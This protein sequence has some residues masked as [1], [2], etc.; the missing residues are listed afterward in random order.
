[1]LPNQISVRSDKV[2]L[3]IYRQN[4]MDIKTV[5]QKEKVEPSAETLALDSTQKNSQNPR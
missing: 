5:E 3:P 4:E 2:T 1:M